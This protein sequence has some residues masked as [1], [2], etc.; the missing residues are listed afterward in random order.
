MQQ[1][2]Y[3]I[4]TRIISE[5][6]NLLPIALKDPKDEMVSGGN[7]ALCIIDENGFVY[8]KMFGDNNPR[9]RQSFKVAWTKASQVWLTGERTGEYE[10]LV[11][12]NQIPENANGIEN[13]DLIG[14]MGGQPLELKNGLKLS[15]G[16]SGFTGPTDIDIVLQACRNLQ[17]I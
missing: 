1:E 12:T 9:L 5:L 6:E 4:I 3:E 2:R 16:F 8:G 14:W 7:V 10:R 11:F 13:P 15:V 17:L